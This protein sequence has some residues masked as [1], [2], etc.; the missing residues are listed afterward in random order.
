MVKNYT[1]LN[2]LQCRKCKRIWNSTSK[3]QKTFAL[4]P[5]ESNIE[6]EI[7]PNW[8]EQLQ[9]GLQKFK[10]DIAK[11][12]KYTKTIHNGWKQINL[13]VINYFSKSASV[14]KL[15]KNYVKEYEIQQV[16]DNSIHF[17]SNKNNSISYQLIKII[18][19]SHL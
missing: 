14:Q 3:G 4:I 2:R 15:Q 7:L 11:Q 9:N 8:I 19:Y 6:M 17:I 12:L 10:M 18:K 13:L 1:H 16:K 5:N